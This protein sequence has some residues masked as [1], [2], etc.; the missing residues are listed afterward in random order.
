MRSSAALCRIWMQRK[1]LVRSR[2]RSIFHLWQI[3]ILIISWRLQRLRT[4]QIRFVLIL[5]ILEM[6]R[7]SVLLLK[8]QKEYGVPIRVGVNS[9]SLEKHLVEKYHGVT[10]EG[11]VEKC[12]G[13]NTAYRGDGI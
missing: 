7:E 1:Q 12:P 8:K 11:L 2:S 4:G 10:A 5:V 9:G 6:S 3:F 13:Q